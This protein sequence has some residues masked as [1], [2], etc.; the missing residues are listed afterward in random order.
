MR[1]KTSIRRSQAAGAKKAGDA[2]D[3]KLVALTLKVDHGTYVRLCTLGATKRRTNQDILS[4]AL[5]EFLDR[6]GS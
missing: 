3:E 4:Q 5:Q 6:V 2:S 1:K